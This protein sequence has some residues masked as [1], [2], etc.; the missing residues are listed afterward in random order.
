MLIVNQ[1]RANRNIGDFTRWKN[2]GVYKATLGRV[3]RD[4][5]AKS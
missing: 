1:L 4:L 2:H 5:R 3:L